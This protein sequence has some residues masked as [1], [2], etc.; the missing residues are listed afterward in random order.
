LRIWEDGLDSARDRPGK[1][2]KE[3]GPEENDYQQKVSRDIPTHFRITAAACIIF[4][5]CA[6]LSFVQL[7]GALFPSG[8]ER[9]LRE[10][11]KEDEGLVEE[12]KA[13]EG[14]RLGVRA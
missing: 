12:E 11:S 7:E 4:L 1:R 9:C 2:P 5:L 6:G 13:R 3:L 14:G 10:A 8:V